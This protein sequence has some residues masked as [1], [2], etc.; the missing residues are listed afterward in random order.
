MP[1]QAGS[2][3]RP[4]GSQISPLASIRGRDWGLPDASAGLTPVTRP[5]HVDCYGDRLVIVP[6]KGL[7]PKSTIPL[8][9]DTESAVDEF[10]SAIWKHMDRWGIAGRNMYWRP[11]LQIHVGPGGQTRCAELSRLLERSGLGVEKHEQ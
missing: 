5:I 9:G 7:A 10:V 3:A 2:P 4:A 1:T 11:T 8:S 6:E